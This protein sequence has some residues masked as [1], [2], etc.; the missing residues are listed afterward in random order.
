MT[1]K[2]SITKVHIWGNRE[3]C[4]ANAKNT[5]LLH[6][7][8]NP[9]LASLGRRQAKHIRSDRTCVHIFTICCLD[10]WLHRLFYR[11]MEEHTE[12]GKNLLGVVLSRD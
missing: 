1:A 8:L 11:R 10:S 3:Q 4:D 12:K 7:L 5:L 9:D 2:L 6:N